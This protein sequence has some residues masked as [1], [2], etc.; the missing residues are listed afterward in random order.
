MSISIPNIFIK[1]DLDNNNNVIVTCLSFSKQIRNKINEIAKTIIK[2]DLSCCKINGTNL[3]ELV[4][5]LKKCTILESLKLGL[6]SINI[7]E[8][9]DI[10]TV[11]TN[12]SNLKE[13]DLSNN[14]IILAETQESSQKLTLLINKLK[15][16][17]SLINL[18]LSCNSI[19]KE[20]I[21]EF[22]KN[23]P[24]CTICWTYY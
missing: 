6:N 17:T 7:D 20:N 22:E 11:I 19:I 13:L 4:E 12:C 5:I 10:V 15:E 8:A 14:N 9:I 3:I 18:N 24:D 21:I 23:L 2:L 16:C 1:K